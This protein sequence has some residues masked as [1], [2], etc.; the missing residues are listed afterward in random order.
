M[1]RSIG[2][3]GEPRPYAES[4]QLGGKQ[5]SDVSSLHRLPC[6]LC[7]SLFELASCPHTTDIVIYFWLSPSVMDAT[8]I[9]DG[10]LVCIKRLSADSDSEQVKIAAVLVGDTSK[11]YPRDY[12]ALFLGLFQ[13]AVDETVSYLIMPF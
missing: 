10:R 8:R 4:S 2:I 3:L 7:E 13:G 6:P 12:Y 1:E 9:S 5:E 11:A